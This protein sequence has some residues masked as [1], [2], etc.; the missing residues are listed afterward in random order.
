MTQT[1]SKKQALLVGWERFK[2][3]PWFLVGLF[4]L[5]TA[6]SW[7]SSTISEHAVGAGVFVFGFIDF[8]LQTLISIG[9]IHV[10]LLVFDEQDA[11]I[12][13][14][15]APVRKIARY[16]FATILAV[17]LIV[18]GFLLLIVPGIIVAIALS[19]VAYRIVDKNEKAIS[20]LRGSWHMTK[21]HRLNLLVFF[22]VLALFNLVGLLALG[23]GIVITAPVSALATV[24]VYRFLD[25]AIP[26]EGVE[27]FWPVNALAAFAIVAVAVFGIAG[28]V[29]SGIFADTVAVE[30]R[31]IQRYID[32]A[33]IQES[34]QEYKARTGMYPST[35]AML[36]DENGVAL[37]LPTD[38]LTGAD[39]A[40]VALPETEDFQL[41]AVLEHADSNT[42]CVYG[43]GV[44][45][46]ANTEN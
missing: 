1:F 34:L 9:L 39:Y 2:E 13:D 8:L 32:V 4:I 31:N 14:V 40:Y 20:A 7:L 45:D 5:T 11:H 36:S 24:Y 27:A 22:L 16:F 3:R 10:A 18:I 26:E 17:L 12:H 38:P 43:L 28:L 33:F 42:M 21:G 30:Q 44:S 6:I 25:G 35:T 15:F 19:F 41:C 37:V 23:I 29:K 46:I